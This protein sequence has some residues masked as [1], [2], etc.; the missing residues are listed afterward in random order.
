MIEV[1]SP[2][3]IGAKRRFHGS[4]DV[5]ELGAHELA[6]LSLVVILHTTGERKREQEKER[7]RRGER[8]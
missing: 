1:W 4:P 8:G 2:L 3:N 5:L 7:E 6:H